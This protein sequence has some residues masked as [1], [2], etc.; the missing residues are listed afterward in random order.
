[1]SASGIR[2][3]PPD[4]VAFARPLVADDGT[5]YPPARWQPDAETLAPSHQWAPMRK[6]AHLGDVART[7]SGE[8][9]IAVAPGGPA[10]FTHRLR[11]VE[12]LDG[13]D[14]S[15]RPGGHG[16]GRRIARDGRSTNT[17]APPLGRAIVCHFVCHL[18]GLQAQSRFLWRP[19]LYEISRSFLR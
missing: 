10:Q 1:V 18:P 5:L 12:E 19:P 8:V 2:T 17:K 14:R 15:G 7:T 13:A 9:L 3:L 11:F 16:D 4:D 6:A